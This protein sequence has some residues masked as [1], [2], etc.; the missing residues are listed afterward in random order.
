MKKNW[1][2]TDELYYG[3]RHLVVKYLDDKEMLM[4]NRVV[5]SSSIEGES[6]K[7]IQRVRSMAVMEIEW[8]RKLANWKMEDSKLQTR[9]LVN[10][11]I[12]DACNCELERQEQELKL[13]LGC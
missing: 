5:F 3:T 11:Y 12:I 9:L 2:K 13:A 1:T 6:R 4:N 10:A 7:L 8:E